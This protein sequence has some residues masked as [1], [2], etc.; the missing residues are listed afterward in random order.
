[1]FNNNFVFIKEE[2]HQNPKLSRFRAL[3]QGQLI[4]I[5]IEYTWKRAI[6]NL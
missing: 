5:S 4:S 1:M 2:L 3:F 6:A